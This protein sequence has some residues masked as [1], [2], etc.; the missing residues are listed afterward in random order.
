MRSKKG[1]TFS[2]HMSLIRA[3][4]RTAWFRW[5]ARVEALEAAK[6]PYT[7]LNKRLKWVYRCNICSELFQL[8]LVQ[9]DHI[10]MVGKLDSY[11]ALPEFC[12]N[13]FCSV[14]N[15][16]VLC[17]PCHKKVTAEQRKRGWK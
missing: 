9:V 7:G 6:E 12:N 5:P 8:K 11:E 3:G 14:S 16:R 15:L 1:W 17:K 2:A 4:V 13:L 10:E